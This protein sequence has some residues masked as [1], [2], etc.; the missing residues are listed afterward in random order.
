MSE[1]IEE[2]K[3]ETPPAIPEPEAPKLVQLSEE[4]KSKALTL[5][6]NLRVLNIQIAA[7]AR[8]NAR[9]SELK[10]CEGKTY[11]PKN[12]ARGFE[13]QTVLI[14]RYEGIAC[15]D[16]TGRSD[17]RNAQ[18]AHIFQAESKNPNFR[19]KPTCTKFLEEFEEVAV[20]KIEINKEVL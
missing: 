12:P 6:E 17:S 5:A 18:N 9:V 10:A 8:F 20:Q 3:P 7:Q 15:I 16:P 13:N 11:K 1:S 4:E 14:E 2:I 19:W